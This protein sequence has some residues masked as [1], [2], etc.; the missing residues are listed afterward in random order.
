[1]EQ[2][3][4]LLR[5]ETEKKNVIARILAVEIEDIKTQFYYPI[6][7]KQEYKHPGGFPQRLGNSDCVVISIK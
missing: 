4:L 2:A 3:E 5:V 1:M 6:D 7:F